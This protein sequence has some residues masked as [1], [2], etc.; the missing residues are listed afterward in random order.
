[1]KE[2]IDWA[3]K[4]E[5]INNL[6]YFESY[7]KPHMWE[8]TVRLDSGWSLFKDMILGLHSG[9]VLNGFKLPYIL[10]PQADVE[11]DG[12]LIE[13]FYNQRYLFSFPGEQFVVLPSLISKIKE[14]GV[15]EQEYNLV[16]YIKDPEVGS[17]I[18]NLKIEVKDNITYSL[19]RGE[20]VPSFE[21]NLIMARW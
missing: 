15:T 16:S 1:M 18:W 3:V 9:D 8:G 19:Y 14:F 4:K 21:K 20:W 2:K 17:E 13:R 11:F 5:S 10:E 6:D 7:I 12:D